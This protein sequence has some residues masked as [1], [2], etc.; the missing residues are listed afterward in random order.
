VERLTF[1]TNLLQEYWRAQSKRD[2]VAQ[3]LDLS[4]AGEV[5]LVVTSRIAN[6]IPDGPLAERLRELPDM[7][8]GQIGG[9]LRLDVSALDGPDMLGSD[10]FGELAQKANAELLRRGRSPNKLPDWRDWDHLHGHFL[11]HRDVFLTWDKRLI[12]GAH[13]LAKQLPITAVTPDNYLAAR[14]IGTDM[15]EHPEE[16]GPE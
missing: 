14:S 7:G 9:I 13:I 4:Q 12:E 8:I 2:L 15:L 6:D 16:N 5:E 3:L 11:K 1:D 10:L